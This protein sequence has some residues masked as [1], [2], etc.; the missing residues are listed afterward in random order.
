MIAGA[1]VLIADVPHLKDLDSVPENEWQPVEAGGDG[2]GDFTQS[3]TEH[4]LTNPILRAAP[5]MGELA[6]NA[7]AR[8]SGK[9]AAE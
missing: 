3:V 6:S 7:K 4:Y 2:S 1:F 9:L 5:L 8:V